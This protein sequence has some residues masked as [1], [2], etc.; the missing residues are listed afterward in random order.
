MVLHSSNETTAALSMFPCCAN[1][2]KLGNHCMGENMLWNQSGGHGTQQDSPLQEETLILIEKSG[3]FLCYLIYSKQHPATLI[4]QLTPS[5][6]PVSSSAIIPSDTIGSTWIK[7]DFRGGGGKD[8]GHFAADEQSLLSSMMRRTDAL[9]ANYRELLGAKKTTKPPGYGKPQSSTSACPHIG[10]LPVGTAWAQGQAWAA[11]DGPLL[12]VPA[13][14]WCGGE[15]Q[16]KSTGTRIRLLEMA[17]LIDVLSE[18][19]ERVLE[20]LPNLTSRMLPRLLWE[21]KPCLKDTWKAGRTKGKGKK[22]WTQP[23]WSKEPSAF[24][25]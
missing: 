6:L 21:Y 14:T 15:K 7:T 8:C 19:K 17:D 22:C 3:G 23:I 16:T 11:R 20:Q 5:V 1:T 10:M 18:Q 13:S 2:H 12:A 24:F 9:W 4:N 25:I